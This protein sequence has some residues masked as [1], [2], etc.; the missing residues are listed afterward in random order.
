MKPLC[1]SREIELLRNDLLAL[2]ERLTEE[3]TRRLELQDE[4][5][6]ISE[7]FRKMTAHAFV[8]ANGNKML[9]GGEAETGLLREN[10]KMAEQ[11]EDTKL[12]LDTES[13]Q[14]RELKH[15][16]ERLS[17]AVADSQTSLYLSGKQQ[18]TMSL[19]DSVMDVELG[20]VDDH[21]FRE[22]EEFL[23]HCSATHGQKVDRSKSKIHTTDFV[24]R[25]FEED[26]EPCLRSGLRSLSKTIYN[27]ILSGCLS[28][29]LEMVMYSGTTRPS[30]SSPT[31][32]ENKCFCCGNTNPV[33]KYRLRLSPSD[34]WKTI[35]SL[36]RDRI[37]AVS[38]F[39]T[40]VSHLQ[41]GVRKTATTM[42]LY[43]DSIFLR[44]QMC[45]A[46]LGC[47]GLLAEAKGLSRA[48]SFSS[49]G[50]ISSLASGAGVSL[51][52]KMRVGPSKLRTNSESYPSNQSHASSQDYLGSNLSVNAP[53]L[54]MLADE[55][56][57]EDSV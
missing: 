43:L 26:V 18:S 10:Q 49:R 38:E 55:H 20:T 7:E 33:E 22:F 3:M 51:R 23:T 52:P 15:R 41:S 32:G 50:S 1:D 28:N 42:E 31:T 17:P 48:G 29:T 25:C 19:A 56:L 45:M 46:R 24:R 54:S 21:L 2:S 47:F 14:L 12:R 8:E 57:N 37:Y 30:P 35:D 11:L 5:R 39:Y 13:S 34:A 4:Q 40:F 53:D 27:K 44:R 36:C 6:K 9:P 16:L